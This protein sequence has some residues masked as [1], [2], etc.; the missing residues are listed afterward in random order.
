MR[1]FQHPWAGK[2]D[3]A[4]QDFSTKISDFDVFK[5]FIGIFLYY[6]L[7]QGK[8]KAITRPQCAIR[9]FDGTLLFALAPFETQE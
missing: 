6:R 5:A 3:F 2:I 1:H 7:Y 9:F 8:L 4:L